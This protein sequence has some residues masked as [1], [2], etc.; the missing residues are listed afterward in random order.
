MNPTISDETLLTALKCWH[1]KALLWA[2]QAGYFAYRVAANV[3]LG[4]AN[5]CG[6]AESLAQSR[7]ELEQLLAKL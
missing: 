4:D 6:N 5:P 3:M 7:Q 2:R 1:Y